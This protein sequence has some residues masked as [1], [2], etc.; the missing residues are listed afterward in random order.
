MGLFSIY[1]GFIYNEFFSFPLTWF[2]SSSFRCMVDGKIVEG[3]DLRGCA[4]E[5]K[6]EVRRR[7]PG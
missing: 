4:S 6:G 5:L 7:P 1:T 3:A 2:G